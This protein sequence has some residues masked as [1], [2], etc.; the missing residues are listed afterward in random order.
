MMK[1]SRKKILMI[2]S[3]LD[4]GGA[5]RIISNITTHL[6]EEWEIDI[7]LNTDRNIQFPFRGNIIFLN[8]EVEQILFTKEEFL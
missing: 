3:S 5:A 7:L 4:G 2:C 1:E 6:P 8:L